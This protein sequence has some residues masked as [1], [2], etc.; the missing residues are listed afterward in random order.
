MKGC[1]LLTMGL[2][3]QTTSQLESKNRIFKC[4]W[5]QTIRQVLHIKH[6]HTCTYALSHTHTHTH[7][8][9]HARTHV[10]EYTHPRVRVH[11]QCKYD[12]TNI[13]MCIPPMCVASQTCC[14]GR[15]L[16]LLVADKI[17][18]DDE[19]WENYLQ[20]MKI[21]DYRIPGIFHGM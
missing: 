16:P 1:S 10:C 8:C 4:Q 20:L 2:L 6:M 13:F 14:L 17:P 12:I 9:T 19:S 18:L 11:T 3:T 5:H 7:T 21:M 15:F